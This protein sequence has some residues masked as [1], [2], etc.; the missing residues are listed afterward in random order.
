MMRGS[1]YLLA[2]VAAGCSPVAAPAGRQQQTPVHGGQAPAAETPPDPALAP[3][4]SLAGAWRV[5]GIDGVAFN[6]AYGLALSADDQ[7]IWWEPRCAGYVR[8]YRIHGAA[9]STG[10]HLGFTPRKAGEPTPPVCAIAPPPRIG[11]VFRAMTSARTI[12]RTPQ[13]GVELSGGG[14]SLLLFSQ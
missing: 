14:H 4:T 2:L 1:V 12:R 8:S 13:N 7:E 6:E 5:A 10:P 9:F 3:V 11:D